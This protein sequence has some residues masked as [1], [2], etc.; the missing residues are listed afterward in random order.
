MAALEHVFSERQ[1]EVELVRPMPLS[2]ILHRR[3]PEL[4]LEDDRGPTSEHPTDRHPV[5]LLL[6]PRQDCEPRRG[7]HDLDERRELAVDRHRVLAL[8][9]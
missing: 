6:G 9:I 7:G 3:G 4:L 2:L 8:G 5:L 1:F